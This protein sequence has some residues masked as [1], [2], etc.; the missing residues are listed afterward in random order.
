[1][2]TASYL[3]SDTNGPRGPRRAH[4]SHAVA[5]GDAAGADHCRFERRLHQLGFAADAAARH[6]EILGQRCPAPRH[7]GVIMRCALLGVGTSPSASDGDPPVLIITLQH[8]QFDSE[9]GTP[10]GPSTGNDKAA[11]TGAVLHRPACLAWSHQAL[12]ALAGANHMMLPTLFNS[13]KHIHPIAYGKLLRPHAGHLG[14]S[15]PCMFSVVVCTPRSYASCRCSCSPTAHPR[16]RPTCFTWTSRAP[17]RA[18][19]HQRRPCFG[20]FA[21]QRHQ[22]VYLLNR[23]CARVD[24]TASQWS[25]MRDHP[26]ERHHLELSAL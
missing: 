17:R 23:S 16:C 1:M 3:C 14:T 5:A 12:P 18:A 7:G 10:A 19:W 4:G 6:C 8:R 24:F 9:A 2:P 22:A 21:S 15:R 13:G 11:G 26:G 25:R 20:R